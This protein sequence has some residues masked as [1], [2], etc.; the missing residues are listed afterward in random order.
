MLV[1]SELSSANDY[2]S[3]LTARNEQLR[4]SGDSLNILLSKSRAGY[5]SLAASYRVLDG[6][7]K[8]LL[9]DGSAE[10]T[11]MLRQLEANQAEL[12]KRSGRIEE[13]N[14]MLAAREKAIED[15]RKKVSDALTGF[16]NKGLTISTRGG[17][18]YVSMEDKLLFKSGSYAIDP[19]GEQAVHNLAG[20]LAANPDI[21]VM[22]EGHTDNV[23]YKSSGELKDNLDLS[24]K[25]ATT[26][27]RLLLDNKS[28]AP[29]RI[30]AAGRGEWLPV[31]NTNTTE[32]RAKNRRTEIIL[33]PKLDELMKLMN[34]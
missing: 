32:G 18:V 26:V 25:R 3:W 11:R 29:E 28:I 23:P 15:I 31:D 27:V 16:E 9:S 2:I 10:A 14:R 1:D 34:N 21:N 19:R 12:D 5:D 8:K 7:Y 6:R 30:T 33:T 24:V 17:Q 22:V 20:V 4:F 13:L